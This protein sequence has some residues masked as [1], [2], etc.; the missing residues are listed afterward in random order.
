M[1]VLAL[2]A[3]LFSVGGC[4]GNDDTGCKYVVATSYG[5]FNCRSIN[6]SSGI[7]SLLDCTDKEGFK[8]GR[9]INP[10]NVQQICSK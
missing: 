5:I 2:L 1:R 4:V 6:R 9:L 8:I 3:L 10:I 7:I